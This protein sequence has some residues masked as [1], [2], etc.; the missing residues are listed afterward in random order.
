MGA[1]QR[2]RPLVCCVAAVA[3]V[4]SMNVL[5]SRRSAQ[6]LAAA[7]QRPADQEAQRVKPSITQA[8]AF[9]KSAQRDGNWEQ[10]PALSAGRPGGVTSLV[11]LALLKS[12]VKADDPAIHKGLAYIRSLEPE[13]TYVLSLQIQVLGILNDK[14]DRARIERNVQAL[15]RNMCRDNRG[16]FQGWSYSRPGP[17]GSGT[18]NSNSHYA[19]VGLH[20]ASKAGVRVDRKLW[21]EIRDYYLRTQLRNGG[22]SYGRHVQSATHTMTCGG[23]CGLC[24]VKEQLGE[25]NKAVDAA[26]AKA[27]NHLGDRFVIDYQTA[28][29]YNLYALSQAGSLAGR[30]VFVGK[31]NQPHDWRLE[32]VRLLLDTQSQTGAWES[33]TGHDAHRLVATSFAL[34][35]LAEKP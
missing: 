15:E 18:D 17:P 19:V 10:V 14:R 4:L 6:A 30:E 5:G 7:A 9:L 27:L 24:I 16:T 28:R 33:P 2:I 31:E 3:F 34:L 21:P 26:L 22:W 11:L 20:A 23:L 29:F 35:F 8:V 13:H 25:E 12:G 1:K 32:G